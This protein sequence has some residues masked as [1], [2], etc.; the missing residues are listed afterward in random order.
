MSTPRIIDSNASTSF[1]GG[2]QVVHVGESHIRFVPI[3]KVAWVDAL[4]L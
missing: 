1:G 2:A 3:R 4:D